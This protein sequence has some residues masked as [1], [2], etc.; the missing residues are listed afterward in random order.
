M[1]ARGSPLPP[2]NISMYARPCHRKIRR[3]ELE[4]KKGQET[5]WRGK[6]RG[7]S[8]LNTARSG[9]LVVSIVSEGCTAM[10]RALSKWVSG[11]RWA[12]NFSPIFPL[13][14]LVCL[15]F[16]FFSFFPLYLFLPRSHMLSAC[17]LHLC[18]RRSEPT[19][20]SALS[21]HQ[22]SQNLVHA[23]AVSHYGSPLVSSSLPVNTIHG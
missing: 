3:K 18:G 17:L 7:R 15:F 8:L 10:Q 14:F 23:V 6:V 22:S 5:L 16:V 4:G 20:R 11:C 9:G 21:V 13:T 2:H 19:V 1:F 12:P